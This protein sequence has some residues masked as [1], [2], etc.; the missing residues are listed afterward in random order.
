MD[1]ARDAAGRALIDG[2]KSVDVCQAYLLMAVYPVPKKKWAEDRSWLLMG[3]AIRYVL[4]TCL[5][6]IFLCH[7]SMAIELELNHPPPP[8][9]DERERLNR[10]RTWLNC[11]CVDGSHAIQ[12]GKIPML[13]LDD[14][15]A[16][17]SADWYRGSTMNIPFDVHLCGYV[18]III[19]VAE[20]RSAW[21]A[22]SNQKSPDVSCSQ[23]LEC[24]LGADPLH[25]KL[26][27]F[28]LSSMYKRD[29][30]KKWRYG[31]RPMRRNIPIIV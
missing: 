6:L 18:Q 8:T 29:Y 20:W 27:L 11:Y 10:T 5:G 2:S 3:V 31:L 30:P 1:F 4:I 14:Y 21:M 25:R 13:P 23:M 16:R 22:N 7:C 15:T 24:T 12:F 28:L 9:C 26:M 19:L 17:H